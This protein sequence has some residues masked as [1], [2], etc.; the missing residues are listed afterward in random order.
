M[1]LRAISGRLSHLEQENRHP[2]I[3]AKPRLLL[4]EMMV[5]SLVLYKYSGQQQQKQPG[6]HRASL[7]APGEPPTASSGRW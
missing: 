6:W 7:A 1:Q 2:K 4:V 3:A 5:S